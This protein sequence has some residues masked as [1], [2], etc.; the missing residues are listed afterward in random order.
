MKLGS[1]RKAV[2][3]GADIREYSSGN[4]RIGFGFSKGDDNFGG[5]RRKELDDFTKSLGKQMNLVMMRMEE[6]KKIRMKMRHKTAM[7]EE[8]KFRR[9]EMEKK[10]QIERIEKNKEWRDKK[11]REYGDMELSD[12]GSIASRKCIEWMV[13]SELK[14]SSCQQD[15]SPPLKIYQC[16]EGHSVCQQCRYLQHGE[17]GPH[18]VV[19]RCT[20]F[21]FLIGLPDLRGGHYREEHDGREHFSNCLF[22]IY[23]F[24]F[25]DFSQHLSV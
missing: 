22:K 6:T 1:N 18:F 7:E 23:Y 8:D 10:N 20:S 14:C 5:Q 12:E 9:K 2:G 25:H 16:G 11:K 21:C 24:V 17:V 13:R 15:M 4:G 3:M 19:E